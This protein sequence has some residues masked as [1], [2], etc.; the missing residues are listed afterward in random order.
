MHPVPKVLRWILGT[1]LQRLSRGKYIIL[2]VSRGQWALNGSVLLLVTAY[3][4]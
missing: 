4:T 1:V 2:C 3:L